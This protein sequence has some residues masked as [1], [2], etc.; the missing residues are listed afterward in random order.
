MPITVTGWLVYGLFMVLLAG[1]VFLPVV[2]QD[3]GQLLAYP[4]FMAHG[5]MLYRDIW[6][7][8][9]PGTYLMLAALMKVG[10]P[11]LVAERGLSIAVHALYPLII[12]RACTGS[13]RRFSWL[14]VLP[15]FAFLFLVANPDIRAYPWNVGL[16]VFM[17]GLVIARRRPR[18]AAFVFL[19]AVAIRLELVAAA[20]PMLVTLG[21]LDA[22]RRRRSL[23]AAVIV[24]AGT[25]LLLGLLSIL[26]SGAAIQQLI[27]DAFIRIPAGRSLP[28][29]L[30][31]LS[32][33]VLPLEGLTILGPPLFAL[34]GLWK[35]RPYIV[36]SN[37]SMAALI[38]HFLQ[39]AEADYLYAVSAA[40]IPWLIISL[41]L[42]CKGDTPAVRSVPR[43]TRR[44][45]TSVLA[46]VAIAG[47]GVTLVLL[48]LYTMLL[49]PLMPGTASSM[50]TFVSREVTNG[51]NTIVA[52]DARVARDDRQVLAYLQ[53]HGAVSQHIYI[54]PIG[55]RHAM[56]DMTS[57][58]FLLQMRP[59]TRYLEM[60]PG[61]ETRASV[62]RD[63]IHSLHTT[64]WVL[65]WRG[66]FWY[67]PNASQKLGS[68]LLARYIP[69]HYRVVFNNHTYEL[70]HRTGA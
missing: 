5:L 11:G 10:I 25:V 38:P 18:L 66:G 35:R 43:G 55:L 6:N 26:T 23:E 22:G 28:L 9:P 39:R 29:R 69:T 49:S 48:V 45:P 8:Y 68:P 64:T 58:Y 61:V 53:V 24:L 7:M 37:V 2:P 52:S 70:L 47:S 15:A 46:A 31:S 44:L 30:F 33:L 54:S 41:M 3:E 13:W 14:A 57:M 12:N 17:G 4:W 32:A 62:Q 56:W 16:A 65:L 21:I 27:V 51:T 63:I 36:A 19:L 1:Q 50:G 20:I 67:E 40:V 60:N 34:A 59:G 42:L